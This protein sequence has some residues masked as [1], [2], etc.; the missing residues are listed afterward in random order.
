MFTIFVDLMNHQES[1]Y[2]KFEVE[3]AGVIWRKWFTT[4]L[5][6][7]RI[8][9]VHHCVTEIKRSNGISF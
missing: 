4:K 8:K 5:K 2:D 1:N 9:Y 6:Y 7:V 3:A